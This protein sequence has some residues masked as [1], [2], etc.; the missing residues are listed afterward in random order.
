MAKRLKRFAMPPLGANF[1]RNSV[2]VIK[3]LRNLVLSFDFPNS[4]SCFRSFVIVF[5]SYPK[6]NILYK[7]DGQTESLTGNTGV[8]ISYNAGHGEAAF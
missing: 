6:K 8:K 4:L 5:S 2:F 1:F 3:I 7:I